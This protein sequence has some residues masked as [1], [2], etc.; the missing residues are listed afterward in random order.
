MSRHGAFSS[1]GSVIRHHCTG[2][3]DRF[4]AAEQNRTNSRLNWP[5]RIGIHHQ[6]RAVGVYHGGQGG[7]ILADY[8]EHD[9]DVGKKETN[10]S[11]EK[12][13]ASR[14]TRRLR[15]PW[16]QRFVAPHA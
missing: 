12:R 2:S 7:F 10:G 11:A 9:I 6:R 8:D 5:R 14:R 1:S 13:V 4:R 3:S 15:G 16:Q